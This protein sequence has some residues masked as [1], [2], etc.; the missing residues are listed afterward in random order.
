MKFFDFP[1]KIKKTI[2]KYTKKKKRYASYV[3]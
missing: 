3:K 2:L 1:F